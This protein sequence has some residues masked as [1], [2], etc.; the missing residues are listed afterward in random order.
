MFGQASCMPQR[1]LHSSR[2]QVGRSRSRLVRCRSAAV[3]VPTTK[4]V[5]SFRIR[6][7]KAEDSQAVADVY[8][9]ASPGTVVGRKEMADASSSWRIIAVVIAPFSPRTY[10]GG[11]C[12]CRR[13]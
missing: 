2:Q 9:Q 3:A 8:S 1:H 12:E 11:I 13:S 5:G 4:S 6:R 10:L 7:A